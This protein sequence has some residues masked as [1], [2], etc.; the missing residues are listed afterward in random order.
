MERRY[1]AVLDVI[2]R[3]KVPE[4]HA[5][6]INLGI[7]EGIS[8]GDLTIYGTFRSFESEVMGLFGGM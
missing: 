3:V 8:R 7:L 2:L 1:S 6:H 5:S 4:D